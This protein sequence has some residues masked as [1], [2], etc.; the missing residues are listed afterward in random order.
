MAYQ[1]KLFAAEIAADNQG[2]GIKI[3]V[4]LHTDG[5]VMF[6]GLTTES[7][8]TD[9]N[10][11]NQGGRSLHKRLFTPTGA[12]PLEGE[13]ITD[14]KSREESRNIGHIVQVMVAVLDPAVVDAFEAGDYKSFV[15]GASLLLNDKKGTKVN[16]K[17]IPDRK[18]QKYP[19]VPSYGTYVER[20]IPGGVSSLKFSKKELEAISL[21]ESNRAN[22][23]TASGAMSSEDL[24]SLV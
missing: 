7:T 10:Y 1:A 18:E 20:H 24:T 11:A 5:S 19:D 2:G 12:S 23:A 15:A 21:M 14:A 6:N 4:G 16:L 9:I 3:P 17:V 8:W 22:T 13:S